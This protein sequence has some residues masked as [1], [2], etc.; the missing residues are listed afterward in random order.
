MGG[1]RAAH[2]QGGALR[3]DLRLRSLT[4]HPMENRSDALKTND[5]DNAL[6]WEGCG[7]EGQQD[8]LTGIS[9]QLGVTAGLDDLVAGRGVGGC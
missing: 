9:G 3:S 4:Y 7:S 2:A 5:F 8:R 6:H 1:A